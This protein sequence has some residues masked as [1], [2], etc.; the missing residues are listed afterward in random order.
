MCMPPPKPPANVP[1]VPPASDPNVANLTTRQRFQQHLSMPFCAGCHEQ[2][3]GVGFGFEHF[4]GIGSYRTS[5]KGQP[6]DSSGS[7]IGTGEIDGAYDGALELT[8]KLSQ[9]RLLADCYV[10]Q[11]YRYA[12]GQIED[13]RD[14]LRALDPNFTTDDAMIDVML[15]LVAHPLLVTRTFESGG[16]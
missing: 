4:D 7:I 14:D 10:R 11:V 15:A 5:E 2:I 1:P 6:V 3:D 9:S 8:T 12:M 16:P 13:P